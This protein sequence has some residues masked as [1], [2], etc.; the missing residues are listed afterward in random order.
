MKYQDIHLADKELFD[1]FKQL[2]NDGSYSAAFKLMESSQLKTK[3]IAED[4]I[5]ELMRQVEALEQQQDPSFKQDKIKL[6]KTPP[7]GMKVGEVYFQE[8]SIVD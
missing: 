2:M 5:N 3:R 1:K 7:A 4:S 6:A 8:D